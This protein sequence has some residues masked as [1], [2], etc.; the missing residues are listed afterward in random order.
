MVM[1]GPKYSKRQKEQFFDLID[2]GG[3]AELLQ[4]QRMCILGLPTHGCA[5]PG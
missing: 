5:T 4:G 3:T 1:A 2:K